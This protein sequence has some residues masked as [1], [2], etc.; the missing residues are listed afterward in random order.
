MSEEIIQKVKMLF[1]TTVFSI[2]NSVKFVTPTFTKTEALTISLMFVMNVILLL[3][4]LSNWE[5]S[6]L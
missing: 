1:A 2:L 6:K 3:S 5:K 4:I